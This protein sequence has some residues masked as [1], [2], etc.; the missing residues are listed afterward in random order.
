MLAP[1]HNARHDRSWSVLD[2]VRS[3]LP[4]ALGLLM[5]LTVLRVSGT[6]DSDVAWQLWIAGRIRAGAGLYKDILETNP[7]LWFW[8]ALPVDWLASTFHVR[9][10][11]VLVLLIGLLTA[12]S[13]VSTDRLLGSDT[14]FRRTLILSYA[15]LA[16]FAVPSVHLGQREQIA[17]ITTLPYVALV[18]ARRDDRPVSMFLAVCVGA[19]AGV[20]FAL[21]VYFLLVPIFLEV[22]LLIGR[23]RRWR[24]LRPE[25]V[26]IVCIGAVYVAAFLTFNADYLTQIVPLLQLAYGAYGAPSLR[27][28]FGLHAIIALFIIAPGAFG[29]LRSQNN[30]NSFGQALWIAAVGFAGCYFIQSKGWTYHSI[31]MLGTSSIALLAMLAQTR[32]AA[33]IRVLGPALLVLPMML[34]IDEYRRPDLPGRDLLQAV[35]GLHAGDTVGFITTETAIP[36]SITLQ[37]QYRYASRYNGFWMFAAIDR[38]DGLANPDPRLAAFR[39]KVVTDTV[40][41]F[42]C[43]SPKRIIVWRPQSGQAAIDI[44]PIFLRDPAFAKLLTH[45]RVTSR[46]SLETYQLVTPLAQ[47]SGACRQN[48]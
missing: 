34:A 12:W 39:D 31:P 3:P 36:W 5:I 32:P 17:L 14:T 21:K 35:E 40:A 44:L 37:R 45:Y 4:L 1:P 7:P 15:V 9:V 18:A 8:M 27:Y 6:V 46:T 38:N 26:T 20:G 41:D 24:P 43:T 48:V 10:E 16:L 22:W 19:L 2:R 11:P 23:G 29:I 25:T 28:L 33:P 47:P 30:Q 42:S 13:I